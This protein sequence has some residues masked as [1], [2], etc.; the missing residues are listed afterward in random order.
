MRGDGAELV[1]EIEGLLTAPLRVAARQAVNVDPVKQIRCRVERLSPLPLVPV[2]TQHLPLEPVQ[3]RH[4]PASGLLDH[5]G[6]EQRSQREMRVF[7]SGITGIR[8]FAPRIRARVLVR[9]LPVR[10]RINPP[11]GYA[12]LGEHSERPDLEAG[13][14]AQSILDAVE[15][16]VHSQQQRRGHVTSVGVPR[17]GVDHLLA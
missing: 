17:N 15:G 13:N 11:R 7:G 1:D 3:H 8:A 14:L 9:L 10:P 5:R 12:R 16:G 4:T 2:L 6:S